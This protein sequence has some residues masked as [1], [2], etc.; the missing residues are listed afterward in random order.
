MMT[1]KDASDGRDLVLLATK[2]KRRLDGK[3]NIHRMFKLLPDENARHGFIFRQVLGPWGRYTEATCLHKVDLNQDG[4]DDVLMCQDGAVGRVYLQNGDG[5]FTQVRWAGK[6][7]M[8]WRNARIADVTGDGIHDLIVVGDTGKHPNK[9]TSYVR[10]FQGTGVDP[11][12]DFSK[13]GIWYEREMPYATPDLEILDVNHDG[14]ADIYV[15]QTD[16]D[17]EGTYCGRFFDKVDWWGST[18]PQPPSSFV[19]PQDEAQD[20]LLVGTGK[21]ESTDFADKFDEVWM[22][23]AVNGCGSF[24]EPFG[25]SYTMLVNHGTMSRPGYGVLLQWY[26]E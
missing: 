22:D 23:H 10:V 1:L 5:S 4:K 21:Y 12:F 3:T 2:G 17:D 24:I 16:E 25:N 15:I 26:P 11:F 13:S 9:P 7:T 14:I 6:H 19:P 20:L 18:I 8:D